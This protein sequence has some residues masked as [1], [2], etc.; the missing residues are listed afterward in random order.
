MSSFYISDVTTANDGEYGEAALLV[1][2]GEIDYQASPQLNALI[3]DHINAGA[4]R[5]VLDLSA[6][7]FVDS[8]AIGVLVSAAT[9]LHDAGGGSLAVVC[10]HEKVLQI[11]E[12]A[13]LEGMVTLYRT[14]EEALFAHARG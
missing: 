6:V 7:T 11:L 12:I 13:G 1:A 2:G 14:R 8:T 3:R 9:R 4:R 10:A 5:L